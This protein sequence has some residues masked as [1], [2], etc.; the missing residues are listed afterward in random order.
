VNVNAFAEYWKGTDFP[1]TFPLT[2]AD[3]D[4]MAAIGWNAVRLLLSWSRVEPAPGQYDEAY[5][6][7]IEDAVHLLAERGIYSIIDLHQDAWGAT[8]VAREDEVCEP[9]M[10]KAFGWDGAP[11]WATLDGG[12]ARCTTAGIRE[13]S[14]AVRTAFQSFWNDTPVALGVGVRTLYAR[15][16]GHLTGRFAGEPAV[17][18]FDVMNE[19]NAFPL[20]EQQALADLYADALHEIRAAEKEA[21][22]RTHLLFF[23]PSALWSALGRGAPPDFTR[24]RDVVYAPHIYT[25]GF[26]GQPITEQAFQIAVDEAKL[27]DGAP[28]FSGEWGADPRRAGDP[29]DGYFLAHQAFQDQFLISA[30]LWTWRESC[31]D[32][33]KAGDYRAGR[34]PYVWG[35]F[36]VDCATNDVTGVRQA[37]VDQLTRGWIRAAPGRLDALDYDPDS[38]RLTASGSNA[39]AGAQLLAFYPTSLKGSPTVES[40][41]LDQMQHLSAP[42]GNI[43][44]NARASGG[45]WTLELRTVTRT[46]RRRSPHSVRAGTGGVP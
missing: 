15:M 35:E 32:P 22:D 11:G 19:P 39:P 23:E 40:Q 41:G 26:D 13:L 27:F 3:A 37:L 21:G 6:A 31:G 5:L 12:A 18:G 33:H 30:T 46:E 38:G 7:Q 42:G 29:E 34:V 8:L 17:A 25:G 9:P 16:L 10:E 20:E 14:P 28:V 24:D 45:N 36:E 4:M 2:A 44:V 1:T 43:Y